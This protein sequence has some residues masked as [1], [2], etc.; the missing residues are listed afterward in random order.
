VQGQS[1]WSGTML[2]VL[3]MIGVI[4]AAAAWFLVA[5]RRQTL[6]VPPAAEA[7][8]R[9]NKAPVSLAD[10]LGELA[11]LRDKGVLSHQEFEAEKAKLLS[12]SS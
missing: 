7:Q 5:S 3:L 12:A 8:A 2:I 11:A 6:Q 1:G 9:A 10:E 4:A